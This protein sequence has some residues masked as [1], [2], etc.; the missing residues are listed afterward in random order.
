MLKERGRV[1]FYY[2]HFGG[3]GHG[4]RIAAICK[5]LKELNHCEIVVIN[6]GKRQP[7]LGIEKYAWVINLPFFEAEHGLFGG[8]KSDEG[9]ADRFKKRG[10]ILNKV[11]EKFKP[12]VAV[13]EHFPFGRAS[14]AGEIRSFIGLLRA[15]GCRIYS[16]VREIIDQKVDVDSLLRHLDLFDGILVHSDKE[17]GFL[18]SFKQPEELKNKLFLTGRVAMNLR[19]DLSKTPAIRRRFHVVG[20]K[21]IVISVGGGIDGEKTVER[22]ISIKKL[23]D[24]GI[25]NSFL[26]S[27]G[28][29]MSVAQYHILK[30]RVKGCQDIVIVRFDA[31]YLQYVAAADLSISMGGYNSIN[32]ALLTGTR[33]MIFPR[34]SDGEQMKRAQWFKEYVELLKEPLSDEELVEKILSCMGRPKAVYPAPMQGA[35]VTARLLD[36]ACGMKYL[37][38]RINSKCNLNCDMCSWKRQSGVLPEAVFRRL[39]L[40]S[41]IA[42]VKIINV[43]GGEPTLLPHIKNILKYIKDNGFRVSLSTNGCIRPVLLKELMGH[44]DMADISLDSSDAAVHDRI[45]GRTGAFQETMVTIRTLSAGQIKPHINVTIRPDNYKSLHQIVPLLAGHI[46]SISFN[47]VDASMHKAKAHK[48][49]FSAKQ[50]KSFYFDELILIF[51]ECI[52]S[53]TKVRVTPFYN[54]FKDKSAR[55]VL[56]NL[57]SKSQEYHSRM[58]QMFLSQNSKCMIPKSQLRINPNGDIA[59]CCFQDDNKN[60]WGNVISQDL[61][62]VVVSDGFYNFIHSATEGTGPCRTCKQGYNEYCT[63]NN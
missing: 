29:N 17:M 36:V 21:W 3:L 41:R 18:T 4:T 5:A 61:C 52:K 45:R 44:I 11:R 13:F 39:I 12:D 47:L 54:E 55:Y 1:L 34:L 58:R 57:L 38:I 15:D 2:H 63:E 40:R 6:S 19:K 32:N 49:T 14:L 20:R 59:F 37:K 30:K 35:Q 7:E 16:S 27:T 62:D 8:L 23:L 25:P 43:T 42:G 28:P 51:K 9:V 31:D 46:D 10:V 24:R 56:S 26:I 60:P 53:G 22:L 48:F 33:T 50:L